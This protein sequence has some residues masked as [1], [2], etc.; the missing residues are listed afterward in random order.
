[1]SQSFSLRAK[2]MAA[3]CCVA[4]ITAIVGITGFV[5]MK[6]IDSKFNEVIESAPLIQTAIN[7]K[8]LVSKDLM[9]DSMATMFKGISGGVGTLTQTSTELSDI[10]SE[11]KDHANDMSESSEVV[12]SFAQKM[13]ERLF[14][15]ALLSAESSS[16][17]DTVSSAVEEMN[18]TVNEIAKDTGEARS[19]TGIAVEKAKSASEKVNEL[20]IDA[21]EIGQVTDVNSIVSSI[22]SAV[23]EQSIT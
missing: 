5:G 1:M 2:S 21:K 23:E 15:V 14:L 7:M 4:L 10:S 20:G 13:N 17:L 22:A 6:K 19:I 3:F 8:L 11:L 18:A 16:N 9:M 12:T